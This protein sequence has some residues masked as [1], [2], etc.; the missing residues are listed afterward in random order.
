[1]YSIEAMMSRMTNTTIVYNLYN[2]ASSPTQSGALPHLFP[3]PVFQCRK[4]TAAHFL[5][6]AKFHGMPFVL[7]ET[8]GKWHQTL[9]FAQGY[10][11]L[12]I[13]HTGTRA[14]RHVEYLKVYVVS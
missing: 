3:S 5:R 10:R 11:L 12:A 6:F 2:S 4:H 8:F 1:M 9:T 14:V 13:S 7:N